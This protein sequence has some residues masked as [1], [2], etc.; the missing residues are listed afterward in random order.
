M[1]LC[2]AQRFGLMAEQW[3]VAELQKRGYEARL[4]S[5]FTAD[6]DIILSGGV[7]VEVKIS[8]CR[9]RYIRP[10]YSRPCYFFD[11]HR[12]PRHRDSIVIL[13]CQDNLGDW[14]PFIAPS[15]YFFG[16]Y[17]VNITSHPTQ[18]RG[19]LADC[20]ERWNNIDTVLARCK[21]NSPQL[22]LF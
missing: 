3:A 7:M 11:L 1:N 14:Y 10:G 19:Y 4:I 16:R 9:K 8:H 5:L 13:I 6:S 17:R 21:N 18:Y 20:L 2:Q 12:L 22:P 15:W